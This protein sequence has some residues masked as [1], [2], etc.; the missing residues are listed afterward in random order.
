MNLKRKINTLRRHPSL[1]SLVM[2][3]R[4]WDFIENKAKT[5]DETE[6]SAFISQLRNNPNELLKDPIYDGGFNRLC[7]VED[8][9]NKEFRAALFD[10]GKQTSVALIHRKDWE[11]AQGVMAMKKFA[12]LDENSIAIGVGSGTEPVPFYLA[13]NIKHVYATDLY[14]QNQAWNR[15]APSDFLKYPERYSPFEYKK[16]ALTVLNMDGTCLDFSADTFDIAFSFS[17][18]EHFGGKRHSGALAAVREIQRVLKPGGLAV[19][20]TEYII[21]N[22]N[23]YEF[24]NRHTIY[25]DLICKLEKLGLVEPLDLRISTSTLNCIIDFFSIDVNWDGL[26]VEYKKNHPAILIRARNI[27]FTSLMLVFRKGQ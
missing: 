18:I 12:K 23:H 9:Q 3:R 19:I 7:S 11:W 17:S 26:S 2:C 27:L 4:D 25:S 13:N 24:F 5:L 10:L 14:G 21:N 20:A 22:K 1:I 15:A 8:W 6:V 16:G